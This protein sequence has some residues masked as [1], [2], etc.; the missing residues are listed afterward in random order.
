MSLPPKSSQKKPSLIRRKRSR[1]KPRKNRKNPNKPETS[2]AVGCFEWSL[3]F[4]AFLET[5]VLRKI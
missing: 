5:G 2:A 1:K 4:E 3:A